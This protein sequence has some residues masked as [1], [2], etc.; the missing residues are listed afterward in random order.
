M[1][2][3]AEL[4]IISAI[5][6]DDGESGTG[7]FRRGRGWERTPRARMKGFQG[8]CIC[9]GP[10]DTASDPL[11]PNSWDGAFLFYWIESVHQRPVPATCT[12]SILHPRDDCKRLRDGRPGGNGLKREAMREW[13]LLVGVKA[14]FARRSSGSWGPWC[15]LWGACVLP[16]SNPGSQTCLSLSTLPSLGGAFSQ[17][18][19]AS[20]EARRQVDFS[21]SPSPGGCQGRRPGH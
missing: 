15:S 9:A 13:L 5:S 1:T 11:R 21:W 19:N 7:P 8:R 16:Q 3:R 20:L 14:T 17:A 6:G 10:G 18:S 12:G 2:G 4:L